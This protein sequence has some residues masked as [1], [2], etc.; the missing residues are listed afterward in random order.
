[1]R[2]TPR[3]FISYAR[4]DREKA[5][6]LYDKF[7]AARFDPW[8]DSEKIRAGETWKPVIR[9]ALR[10]SEFVVVLLSEISI[11]N[12]GYFQFEIDESLA[13]LEEKP[14]G[15]K[16]IFPLRLSDCRVPKKLAGFQYVDLFGPSGWSK[17]LQSLRDEIGGRVPHDKVSRVTKRSAPTESSPELKLPSSLT[18]KPFAYPRPRWLTPSQRSRL[19]EVAK[20]A[21]VLLLFEQTETGCWGKSYLPHRLS[22]AKPC[23][24]LW[25][26]SPGLHLLY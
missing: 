7:L 10:N 16:F 9:R 19:T 15:T 13:L 25:V 17:L 24:S 20:A 22:T 12:R 8:M 26:L 2:K 11:R 6:E 3:V 18:T 1:M 14:R 5:S 23:R 4:K 21:F